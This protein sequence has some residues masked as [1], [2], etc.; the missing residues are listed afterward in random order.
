MARWHRWHRRSL[1]FLFLTGLGLVLVMTNLSFNVTPNQAFYNG[2]A[3]VSST[4]LQ[5]Q[6]KK[7]IVYMRVPGDS[8]SG[9]IIRREANKYTVM[10]AYHV[11]RAIR[12]KSSNPEETQPIS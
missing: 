7:F 9:V 6:A 8:G 12:V 3:I 11:V 10:T 1:Q 4:E 5:E 2:Q